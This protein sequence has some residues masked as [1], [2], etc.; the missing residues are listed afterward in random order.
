MTIR[1]KQNGLSMIELLVALALSSFLILGV[2]QLYLDNKRNY[3]FQLSQGYNQENIR[4][5]E[6]VLSKWINRAGY[7]RSPDQLFDTA[8]EA[9]PQ[10]S[11]CAAFAKGATVTSLRA[12]NVKGLCIRYQ[13][14]HA[15]ELDCQGNTVKSIAH[16]RLNTAFVSPSKTEMVTSAIR[17]VQSN[18]LNKGTLECKNINSSQDNNDYMELVDGVADLNIEFA[19]GPEDLME[20]K[21]KSGTP[22]VASVNDKQVPR[23][24]RYSILV[25]S[26][27]NQRDGDSEIF[28]NWVNTQATGASKQRIQ[29]NDGNRI[30]QTASAVVSVR[31]MMP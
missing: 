1:G 21:I 17:F 11:D 10:S 4:Y 15:E 27:R 22:W 29:A 16:T 8:F 28:N 23:A 12:T 31:S 13:P 25:A 3:R 20:R 19:I 24:V 5:A 14:A 30:Y 7:R 18:D 26:D 6:F 2:T 9:V